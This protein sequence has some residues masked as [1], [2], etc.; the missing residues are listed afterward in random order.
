MA[1]IEL[2]ST[3]RQSNITRSVITCRKVEAIK[4]KALFIDFNA[5]FDRSC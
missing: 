2:F 5:K 4:G 3:L 1:V